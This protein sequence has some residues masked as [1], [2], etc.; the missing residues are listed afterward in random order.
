MNRIR[1][2]VLRSL[3]KQT[4]KAVEAQENKSSFTMFTN[5]LQ[6]LNY[7]IET[8]QNHFYH[9]VPKFQLEA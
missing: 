2:N 4:L 6:A 7:K 9:K 8:Y 1:L 5:K 3:D